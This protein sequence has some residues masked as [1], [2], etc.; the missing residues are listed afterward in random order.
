MPDWLE[1]ALHF[2]GGVFVLYLAFGTYKV[3]KNFDVK[4]TVEVQSSKTTI[5]KAVFVNFLSPGPY[6]G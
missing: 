1:Q 6:L 2:S 3:W 4:K 5:L